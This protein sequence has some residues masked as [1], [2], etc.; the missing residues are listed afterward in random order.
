VFL[1]VI[2]IILTYAPF[3]LL[4]RDMFAQD[5]L[6]MSMNR[7]LRV[8]FHPATDARQQIDKS[9]NG[10]RRLRHPVA[11]STKLCH[12]CKLATILRTKQQL[13]FVQSLPSAIS[14]AFCVISQPAKSSKQKIGSAQSNC[15]E[16]RA[17]AVAGFGFQG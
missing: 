7:C 1:Y 14:I 11:V 3:A 12:A 5:R 9:L 4:S 17:A 13:L 15:A 2:C 8:R 16:R 6:G 10:V